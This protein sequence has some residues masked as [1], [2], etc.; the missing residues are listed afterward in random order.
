MKHFDW[1]FSIIRQLPSYQ[2]II[3]LGWRDTT[4]PAQRS[5]GN[6]DFSGNPKIASE[7]ITIY[8]DGQIRGYSEATYYKSLQPG[9]WADLRPYRI[10]KELSTINSEVDYEP[11]LA[12]AYHYLVKRIHRYDKWLLANAKD[13]IRIF[14]DHEDVILRT[15]FR[16]NKDFF[17]RFQFPI[18]RLH[19]PNI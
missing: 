11:L 18:K 10:K 9:K 17:D 14:F 16:S 2:K 15:D 6:I 7:K 13:L 4:T 19:K 5:H 12:I 1:D 8:H 3:G